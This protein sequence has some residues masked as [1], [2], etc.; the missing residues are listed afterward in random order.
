M[1]IRAGYTVGRTT[2]E[3]S[4]RDQLNQFKTRNFEA[5]NNEEILK[6]YPGR[7]SLVSKCIKVIVDNFETTPVKDVLP[8]Q[9]MAEITERLPTSLSPIIGAKYVFNENY[10]KRCAVEKYGWHNCN[11]A[12]HGLLWKQLYFE[13]LM[14]DKLE[15]FDPATEDQGTLYELVDACSDYIFTIAFSQLPSHID[16][17][18]LLSYLPN[19]SRMEI[20][21]GVKKVGMNYERMLFGMK[22]ADATALAKAFHHAETL[23]TLILS[24]NM[25]DDDLLRMLMSGLIKNNTVTSLD[26][27]H[28]KITNHGTRLLSKLLGENSVLTNLNLADNHIHTDGG[29]YLA[30]G[31]RENDSLLYLNL[32]LNQ[33]MDDGCEMLFDGLQ[34]N[35]CLTDLNISSNGAGHQVSIINKTP[36][37]F[38]TG[39]IFAE[40]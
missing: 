20:C 28:N 7:E 36:C 14:R 12:E 19:L 13:K 15:D 17:S 33:L 18:E 35:R 1:S 40:V 9:Q 30:R 2:G 26:L 4:L 5:D 23:T 22:I 39:N 24:G 8:P 31:L 38:I 25:I 10:W 11:I 3:S 29:R 6:R 37:G 27:S 16:L 21:Y 32:R 34:E